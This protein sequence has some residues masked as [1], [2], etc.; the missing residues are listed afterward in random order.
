[1]YIQLVQRTL[2]YVSKGVNRGEKRAIAKGNTFA[3]DV[4][5]IVNVTSSTVA[6]VLIRN[7]NFATVK[8]QK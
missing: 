5:D 2:Q 7:H 8:T 3:L 4:L 1:M 6:M